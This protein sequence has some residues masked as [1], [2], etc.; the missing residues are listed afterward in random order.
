VNYAKQYDAL[1]REFDAF[2]EGDWNRNL[3]WSWLYSL[4]SLLSECPQGYPNFMRTDAWQK[5]QLNAAL[6]SWTELRHDTIL[7]AK[8][9]YTPSSKGGVRPP[10]NATGYV[11]PVPQ[12]YRRLWSLANMTRT[13]LS[14]LGALSEQGAQRL[15]SLENMLRRLAEIADKELTNQE[16][17]DDD[18]E[19][20]GDFAETL[21]EAVVGIEGKGVSTILVADVHTHSF[22]GRVVEEAVGYVDIL[23][24]AC[25]LSNGSIILAAGPV[26]S[27]YE[28]KWP[29][30]NRLTD[31]EW[32]SL[33]DSPDRPDRP[34][35]YQPFLR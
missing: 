11:E 14:A 17:S 13:G 35:W 24:V 5:K 16:L 9:S 33:L 28:F 34:K 18:F 1:K 23:I 2:D 3:Y 15:Q 30:S 26:L 12:F 20:I 7:Y 25:P 8:Q 6:S 31:E 27:Y 4:R 32:R 22:E 10:P 19:Y 29:M 21:E